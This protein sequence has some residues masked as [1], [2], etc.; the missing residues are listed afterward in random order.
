M[1][2]LQKKIVFEQNVHKIVLT[3]NSCSGEMIEKEVND[4]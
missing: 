3:W 1:S 2:D 4:P